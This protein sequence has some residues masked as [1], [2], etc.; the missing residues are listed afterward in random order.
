[1]IPVLKNTILMSTNEPMYYD[2]I[3]VNKSFIPN[4]SGKVTYGLSEDIRVD[5]KASTENPIIYYASNSVQ[6]LVTNFNHEGKD[7]FHF[8]KDYI[9]PNN[10]SAR[11]GGEFLIYLDAI[12]TIEFLCGTWKALYPKASAEQLWD[13]YERVLADSV[14]SQLKTRVDTKYLRASQDAQLGYY[15]ENKDDFLSI[16][17]STGPFNISEDI[18]YDLLPL[19]M[20]LLRYFHNGEK[21]DLLHKELL[22]LVWHEVNIEHMEFRKSLQL[23]FLNMHLFFPEYFDGKE[24]WSMDFKDLEKIFNDK[25]LKGNI[26]Y[27]RLQHFVERGS[28]ESLSS[29]WDIAEI[30]KVWGLC[31]ERR[32]KY[33]GKEFPELIPV[34]PVAENLVSRIEVFLSKNSKPTLEQ[35]IEFLFSKWPI[36]WPVYY[37]KYKNNKELA[38]VF[39]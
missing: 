3:S 7:L 24:A 30:T 23:H 2:S 22:D 37:Y 14:F 35:I 32:I 16:C 8:L 6:D 4:N 25:I 20:K 17:N 34:Y 38:S 26:G 10:R 5:T 1:M 15:L 39:I 18:K 28:Y 19:D 12:S 31:R 21:T 27:L 13:H 9:C 29:K 33:M 11:N 36:K